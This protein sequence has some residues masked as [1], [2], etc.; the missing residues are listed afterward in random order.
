EAASS[1]KKKRPTYPAALIPY[2]STYTFPGNIRELQSMVYDA[3]SRH[4]TG[5][6]S[7]SFFKEYM[8]EQRAE[9]GILPPTGP[10]CRISYSGPFPT[11]K[12]TEDFLINE[13]LKMAEGNQSIAARLLGVSQSTL[14][15]RLSGKTR[16]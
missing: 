6:L 8:K 15:R 5:V 7:L 1:L 11:L 14:S 16:A 4:E 10:G 9:P 13:A 3:L 12:E 2:L